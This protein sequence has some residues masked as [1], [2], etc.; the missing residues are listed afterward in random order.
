MLRKEKK[1]FNKK[2]NIEIYSNKKKG[3]GKKNVRN[4]TIGNY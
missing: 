4:K 3:G 1:Q 2:N